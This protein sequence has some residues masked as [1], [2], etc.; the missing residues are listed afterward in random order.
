M[1]KEIKTLIIDDEP[2]ARESLRIFLS[3][4]PEFKIIDECTNGLEAIESINANRPDLIFLDIQ[5]P[6]LNGFDVLNEIDPEIMPV[7]IFATAYDKYAL[8]A[9]DANAIDYLLK[10]FS[11]PR[12]EEALL[13]TLKFL[14]GQHQENI[15]LIKKLLTAYD[16]YRKEEEQFINRILVK[17]KKK[18]FFIKLED[19]YYFEA[20][21]DYV[22]IH[23][24]KTK[25]WI[26]ESMSNLESKLDPNHFIRIHRSTIIN[27][28]HIEDLQPYFN[29]EF[30]ITMKNGD[31]LK[32]S[33]NYKDKIKFLLSG[34][35]F[36]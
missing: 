16:S 2:F 14:R 13:K 18:Y 17:E 12:F 11:K 22:I 15:E 29:G 34:Q 20:S 24:E 27:I 10:P 7:I 25:H 23:K 30:F 6:E 1:M 5:M 31:R 19:I 26:N 28:N 32:L 33:R 36:N 3:E 21:S 9:F 4:H 35:A 8:K